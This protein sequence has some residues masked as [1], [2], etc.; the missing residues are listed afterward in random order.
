[1][2]RVRSGPEDQEMWWLIKSSR[3]KEYFQFGELIK[4]DMLTAIRVG[5]EETTGSGISPVVYVCGILD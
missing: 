4:P 3:N 1:M 2:Q 5:G